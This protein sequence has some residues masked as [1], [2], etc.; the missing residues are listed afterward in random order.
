[1]S[2]RRK[3]KIKK[4]ERV[5]DDKK[6]TRYQLKWG[7]PDGG[8]ETLSVCSLPLGYDD[9]L[10]KKY[11]IQ[12]LTSAL[13]LYDRKLDEARTIE[14]VSLYES[15]WIKADST[16]KEANMELTK[17]MCREIVEKPQEW[18]DQL[19]REEWQWL[20]LLVASAIKKIPIKETYYLLYHDLVTHFGSSLSKR[21]LTG[22]EVSEIMKQFHD[23]HLDPTIKKKSF[24]NTV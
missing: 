3:Q 14:E 22:E 1:M 23:Q 11:N 10:V 18:F 15:K 21:E 17:E 2:S 4:K 5:K 13:M 8:E 6:R 20:G 9:Y 12:E 24:L 16:L 7:Y 19:G